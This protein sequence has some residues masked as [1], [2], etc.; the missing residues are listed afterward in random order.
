VSFDASGSSDPNAGGSIMSYAWDFGDAS[1]A[2]SGVQPTHSYS[3]AGT[4]T[5]KLTVSDA[6]NTATATH[7]V[8]IVGPPSAA[9][10]AIPNPATPGSLISFN[11][12]GS[13]DP[14]TTI[15]SYSWSFGDG[16]SGTGGTPTHSYPAA[17]TYTVTLTVGDNFGET[18]TTTH[19]I[20][21]VGPPSAAF[22][23]TPNTTTAGSLVS[24]NA[25][26]STDPGATITSYSWSFG[27]AGTGTGATPTHSCQAAGTYTVT[28]TVGDNFG[29]TAATTRTITVGP[30][31]LRG[32]LS[33]PK[34][35]SLLGVLEHGLVITL[36]VNESG[37]AS[38]EITTPIKPRRK[39][40]S[41]P[42]TSLTL[43]QVAGRAVSAGTDR[44]ELKLIGTRARKLRAYRMLLLTVLVTLTDDYGQQLTLSTSVTLK[45]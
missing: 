24:F 35:Q 41:L 32:H 19:T 6:T 37:K 22:A 18:A 36:A 9:F 20:T 21:V 4:Y 15:T 13:T 17:G 45:R 34:R 27:D 39:A 44:V 23:V 5:V 11:A 29:E 43:S 7:V 16:S 14:G 38:F 42:A 33:I 1:G 30:P 31:P 2:G 3:S 26:G 28:L 25:G 40:R 10:A 8:R 12:G